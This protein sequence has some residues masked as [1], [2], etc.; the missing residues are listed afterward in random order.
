MGLVENASSLPGFGWFKPCL[1]PQDLVY[2]GLRDL[3]PAE[4]VTIRRL[5]I[6]A[7]TVSGAV[8]TEDDMRFPFLKR[9]AESL[10]VSL[11]LSSLSLLMWSCLVH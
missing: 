4:K 6:K 1:A 9:R 7:F 11:S 2:I 10:A 3:D 8:H 5:G